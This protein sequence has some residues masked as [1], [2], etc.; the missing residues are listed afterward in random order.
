MRRLTR[1]VAAFAL[2]AAA[3]LGACSDDGTSSETGTGAGF[4]RK[5]VEAGEVTVKLTPERIDG[6]GAAFD[7]A[8]DTHSVELGLDVAAN[9]RLVVEGTAWT[10]ATWGGA[11]PGGHHRDGTLRFTAAGEA[12]GTAEVTI[13]GLPEPV[14]ATWNLEDQ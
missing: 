2:G 3:L 1:L 5:T 13:D 14:R 4:A 9:A 11:G 12:T 10:D 8:F 6:D 7:V